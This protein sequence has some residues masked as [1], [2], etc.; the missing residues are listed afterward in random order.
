MAT[1]FDVAE[2]ILQQRGQLTSM[3]LQKLVY[4]SQA[5]N[6]VWQ[7]TPL[8]LERIEA[9]ANGAVIRDLYFAHKG[10]LYVSPGS[11][12]QGNPN[13]LSDEQKRN[14]NK[15]LD[16]Y[17]DYTAQQL[18]DINHQEKPWIDARGDLKPMAISD[19]EITPSSM[20][21]YYSGIFDEQQEG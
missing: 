5:W 8:F 15:V 3:K 10:Q 7:E 13:A 6:L 4:Y 16:F 12:G 14:I 9:W 11:L 17:G 21:Q 18:S 19:S 2:Y 20:H 1:A